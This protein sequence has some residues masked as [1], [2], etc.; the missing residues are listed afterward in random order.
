[1]SFALLTPWM[2]WK[3]QND[4]IFNNARPSTSN[5]INR[6]K[7]EATQWLGIVLSIN[8]GCATMRVFC[9][10]FRLFGGL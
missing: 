2:I 8:L 6:I 7:D 5:L 4:Y 9:F 3:H 10:D 1:M